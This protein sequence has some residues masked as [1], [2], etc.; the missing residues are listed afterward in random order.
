MRASKQSNEFAR[1][2]F[3]LSIEGDQISAERVAAVLAH[4][5]LHPP[6][7]PLA[8]L[9][10]YYRLVARQLAR[11]RALVEH[12]GPVD[13][14]L[15]RAIEVAFTR[16][17]RRPI[18]AAARPNPDLIAGLRVRIGDDVYEASVAGQLAVLSAHA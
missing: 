14:G 4:L 6:R 16:K 9:R 1:Q 5:A 8:V 12:G 17:Y 13:D 7:Q 15:L 11:N 18:A 10:R 3:R 2:L